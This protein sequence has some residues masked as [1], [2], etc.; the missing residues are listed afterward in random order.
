[1]T[2]TRLFLLLTILPLIELALLLLMGKY[3][4]V[5][6]TLAFVLLTGLAGAILLRHQGI[7]TFRNIQRDLAEKRMPTDSLLDGVFIAVA[8]ILLILPGVT[9]DIVGMTILIPPLRKL[10]KIWLV[11]WFKSKFQLRG[12]TAPAR[13]EVI[14][15]HIVD[16][17]EPDE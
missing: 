13:T 15:S 11:R 2:L 7:Q 17:R 10:Y 1:M 16:A 8:A 5:W 9:T 6:F 14:D 4:S 12:F 3:I